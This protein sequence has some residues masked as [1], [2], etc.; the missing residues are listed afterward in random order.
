MLH[1]NGRR[2]HHHIAYYRGPPPGLDNP[3]AWFDFTDYPKKKGN[4]AGKITQEQII[5]SIYANLRPSNSTQRLFLRTRLQDTW[6]KWDPNH[7]MCLSKGEF[8]QCGI[9]PFLNKLQREFVKLYKQGRLKKP[10][11]ATISRMSLGR[12]PKL[13]SGREW[14][15]HYDTSNDKLLSQEEVM[16]GIIES[17]KVKSNYEKDAIRDTVERAW[18]VFDDDY[19]GQIDQWEFLVKGGLHDYLILLDD[20]WKSRPKDRSSKHFLN[21]YFKAARRHTIIPPPSLSD[22]ALWFK[23][24]DFDH[25][26]ILTEKEAMNGL[27]ATLNATT[28]KQRMSVRRFITGIW[29]DEDEV[30]R[31][32]GFMKDGGF[33]SKF[34]EFE[35]DWKE[36]FYLGE[37]EAEEDTTTIKIKV[38]IPSDKKPGDVLQVASPKTQELL[39]L[40]IPEKLLWGGGEGE[41]YF[42]HVIF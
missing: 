12:P 13:S 39:L 34:Q 41:P 15:S 3:Q 6:T 24:F 38:Q 7:Q 11:E 36:E 25:A 22:P 17:F 18:P 10:K 26:G 27:Y 28:P 19:S 21:L 16:L 40:L 35:R 37:I 31:I 30:M 9:V 8:L 2:R 1:I 29:D 33:A 42:F 32:E 20:E 23:H 14:F 5:N 4:M